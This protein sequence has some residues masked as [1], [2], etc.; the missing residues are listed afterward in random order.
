[1]HAASHISMNMLFLCDNDSLNEQSS[2]SAFF[3]G[4]SLTKLCD[5]QVLSEQKEYVTQVA[6]LF[7]FNEVIA[8][9]A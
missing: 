5:V 7:L 1:M 3:Q 6:S 9:F 2:I 8:I 4:V